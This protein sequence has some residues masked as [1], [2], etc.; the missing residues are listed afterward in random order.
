MPAVLIGVGTV[1][2]RFLEGWSWFNSFYVAVIT[3]TS[4][5]HSETTYLSTSGH[6]FTMAL[7]LGGIFTVAVAVTELLSTIITGELRNFWWTWRMSKR[8]EAL[9]QQVIVCGYGHIGRHVCADLLEGGVPVVVIDR[10][11]TALE[12]THD[13]GAL[14]L[15]GDATADATLGRAGIAR[16][17]ALVAVAGTDSDNVLITMTARLLCPLLPIVSCAE[18]ESMVRKLERAGATRVVSRH[19]IAGGLMAQ[20]VLRPALL[21]FIEEATGKR[22]P[23]LRMEEQ[24]VGAG[25]PLDGQTVGTSGLRSRAGQVLVAIKRPDGSLAFNPGDGDPVAAGDILI[26]LGSREEL[27]RAAALTLSR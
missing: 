20:A 7:A 13:A 5:G 12:T 23:D 15:I 21:D 11:E 16:A 17:R 8:I 3:L 27:G 4:I 24:L 18:E 6:L 26:T 19:A 2:Y 9:E 1:G 25:S 14:L 10:L 22:H